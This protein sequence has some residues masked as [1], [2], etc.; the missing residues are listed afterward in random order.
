MDG[1]VGLASVETHCPYCA[2]QCGMKLSAGACGRVA[3]WTRARDFPTNKGGLCQKGWTAA[4]L[5]DSPDRLTTPLVRDAKGGRC[6]RRPG[7]RRSAAS[8]TA[9][10]RSRPRTGRT[11]WAC[12]AAAA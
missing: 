6:A 3:A 9:S 8:R 5:L 1:G 10:R 11:R 7:T 12:S 4:A 2:L